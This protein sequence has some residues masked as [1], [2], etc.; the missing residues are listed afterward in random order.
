MF[1]QPWEALPNGLNNK[2]YEKYNFCCVVTLQKIGP[3][4]S[5]KN[6]PKEF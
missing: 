3:T 6:S 5:T 4:E 2:N 1:K